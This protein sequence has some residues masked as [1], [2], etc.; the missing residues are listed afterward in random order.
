MAER[1]QSPDVLAALLSPEPLSPE[2]LSPEPL[3]AERPA[4]DALKP[5]PPPAPGAQQKAAPAPDARPKRSP[6]PA[7]EPAAVAWETQIVTFQEHRG[8][9]PRY[10]DGVEAPNWLAGPLVHDYLNLRGADGWEL[11]AASAAARFY[12]VADGLQ[13]FLKRRK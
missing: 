7:P 3:G 10:V 2:P 11:A 9:R 5:A 6:Q 1:K 12:G 13:L 8:W 4:A